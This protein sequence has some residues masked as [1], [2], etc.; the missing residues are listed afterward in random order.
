MMQLFRKRTPM[1]SEPF[2]RLAILAWCPVLLLGTITITGCSGNKS[3]SQESIEHLQSVCTV[4]GIPDSVT[5]NSLHTVTFSWQNI[6]Q[7]LL[8][9]NVMVKVHFANSDGKILFQ[10]DHVLPSPPTSYSR[11]ILVPLIPRRQKIQAMVGLYL[12]ESTQKFS[13]QNASGGSGTKVIVRE[14]TV[15]PPMNID[16]LPEARIVFGD[17]WHQKEF[18]PGSNNSWRWMSSRGV[19][20]LKGA[21]RDLT[22]YLHGWVPID[23]LNGPVS[24]ELVLDGQ[25]LG[26]YPNLSDEFIIKRVIEKGTIVNGEMAELV[27]SSDKGF[28]PTD[29]EETSDS[30]ELSVM[31]KQFDFN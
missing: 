24:M 25:S 22:L 23:K 30:R 3:A 20:Q 16:D 8:E 2:Y 15:A 12:N 19:C 27:L 28:R 9:Q 17:G 13:I 26:V 21:D 11:E 7:N 31:I 6:P 14:F 29:F 10:D 18:G 5:G 1:L 4:E